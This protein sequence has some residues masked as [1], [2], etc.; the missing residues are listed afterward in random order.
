MTAVLP[1][2]LGGR[3]FRGP[4]LARQRRI[5]RPPAVVPET[6][7]QPPTPRVHYD[8][9]SGGGSVDSWTPPAAC[10][11]CSLSSRSAG[12]RAM[13]LTSRR[14]GR[15]WCRRPG[16]RR[17]ACPRGCGCRSPRCGWTRRPRLTIELITIPI[18]RIQLLVLNC[19]CRLGAG[20]GPGCAMASR[21]GAVRS[22][23]RWP[24][25]KILSMRSASSS[26]GSHDWGWADG[27]HAVCGLG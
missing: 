2:H 26:P 3:I 1:R 21:P 14:P 24:A 5:C 4:A 18:S 27:L 10:R 13:R 8:A 11:S 20:P 16:S 12:W 19:A 25:R 22:A 7:E 23:A 15:S 9:L 6:G 17:T